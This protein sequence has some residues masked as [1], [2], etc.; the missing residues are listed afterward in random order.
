MLQV[1]LELDMRTA[2]AKI[3]VGAVIIPASHVSP[4]S[5]RLLWATPSS[6]RFKN[7][8]LTPFIWST[9]FNLFLNTWLHPQLWCNGN[10]QTGG[11]AAHDWHVNARRR[12][13]VCQK[14]WG[15]VASWCC[16]WFWCCNVVDVCNVGALY[17]AVLAGQK[18][19][20]WVRLQRCSLD[21][22]LAHKQGRARL[23]GHSWSFRTYAGRITKW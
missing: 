10:W 14:I 17:S 13:W 20:C 18:S 19:T 4:W 16:S 21:Q 8:L 15:R 22:N 23:D 1:T 7:E 5:W 3:P 11:W 12:D 9:V 2:L 6:S